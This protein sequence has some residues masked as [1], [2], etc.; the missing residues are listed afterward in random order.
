[1]EEKV[2]YL[3][4]IFDKFLKDNNAYDAWYE[5]YRL[6]NLAYED[7]VPIEKFLG[8]MIKDGKGGIH[9]IFYSGIAGTCM[10]AYTNKTDKFFEENK[11]CDILNNTDIIELDDK[12]MSTWKN[13]V[14][15]S[16]LEIE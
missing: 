6:D 7:D 3:K 16:K 1:M 8:D 11:K 2:K 5:R 10:C 4:E 13:L 15:M 14:D 12:W 9:S